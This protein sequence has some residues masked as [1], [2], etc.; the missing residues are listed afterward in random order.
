MTLLTGL[1][2]PV[3]AFNEVALRIGRGVAILAIAL[4]VVAIL[5]QVFFRYALNNPLPWPD[6]A[7]RF[8]MLWM[9]GLIAPTAYRHGGFVA[10]DTAQRAMP[11]RSAAVLSLALLAMSGLVLGMAIEIGWGEITGFLSKASTA[12]LYFLDS[13]LDW[14]KLPRRWMMASFF[15]CVVLLFTVNVEL[16]LRTLITLAGGGVHLKDLAPGENGSTAE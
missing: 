11:E 5:V 2:T 3:Q 13:S 4:M 6:E 16:F 15:V 1:L 7:A 8:A 14:V 10:I 12:S 9:T